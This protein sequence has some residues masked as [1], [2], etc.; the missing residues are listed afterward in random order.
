MGALPTS[1]PVLL[2]ILSGKEKKKRKKNEKELTSRRYTK[3]KKE[4]QVT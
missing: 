1:G 3:R 4:R 2:K